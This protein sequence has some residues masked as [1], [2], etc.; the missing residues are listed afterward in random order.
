MRADVDVE[1]VRPACRSRSTRGDCSQTAQPSSCRSAAID[2]RCVP[3]RR[4]PSARERR[5]RGRRGRSGGRPARRRRGRGR[6]RAPPLRRDTSPPA[7]CS[8]ATN[9]A[10]G[11]PGSA[12]RRRRPRPRRCRCGSASRPRRAAASG[13]SSIGSPRLTQ[14]RRKIRAKLA[15]TTACTPHAFIAC[16]DVLARRAEP[17]VPAGDDD[18]VVAELVAQR[19]VVAL[20]QVL[21]HQLRI[22]DVQEPR[23][24]T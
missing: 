3:S 18:R 12:G 13:A 8:S 22:V 14:L 11:G 15:P 17:E 5:R 20:E 2:E 7:A 24:D 4:L 16:S 10:T 6:S 21:L 9:G 1:E 23:R 19:R